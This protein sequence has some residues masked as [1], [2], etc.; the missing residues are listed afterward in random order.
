MYVECRFWDFGL[1][2][3]VRDM[4][5]DPKFRAYYRLPRPYT[6]PGSYF[7]SRAFKD[8]DHKAGGIVGPGRP[9]WVPRTVMLQF[10]GDAVSL[11]NFGNRSATVIG[12][13]CE[14]LP[15]EVCQTNLAWRPLIIVEGPKETTVLSGI[16]ARTIGSLQ[17]HAPMAM[18]G[19]AYVGLLLEWSQ[20]NQGT[21]WFSHHI[22]LCRSGR[23]N[24]ACF[25]IR[26]RCQSSQQH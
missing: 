7:C 8:Y 19:S 23:A 12:I 24:H 6:D 4:F 16:L 14:D 2:Q 9:H 17:E 3:A 11:L 21:C 10:G 5:A 18:A 25:V 26:R 13:R 22:A 1:V 20:S 15:G